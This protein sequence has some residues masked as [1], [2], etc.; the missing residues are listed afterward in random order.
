MKRPLQLSWPGADGHTPTCKMLRALRMSP[1]ERVTRAFIPS[2]VTSTLENNTRGSE[3]VGIQPAAPRWQGMGQRGRGGIPR[4]P[5][6]LDDVLEPRH[7]QLR[8]QGAEAEAGAAGLQ[9]GNDL[10]QVVADEAEPGV[11]C[12]LLDHCKKDGGEEGPWL[13]PRPDSHP[14]LGWMRPMAAHSVGFLWCGIPSAPHLS[15][16]RSEHP[17]SWHR[18]HPG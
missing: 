18:L 4:S 3:T 12:E 16:G 13:M 15:S 14:V 9:G 6:L 5:L 17:G 7:H 11:F 8:G 10:G 2:S 1:L